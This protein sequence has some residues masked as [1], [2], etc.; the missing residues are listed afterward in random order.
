VLGCKSGIIRPNIPVW[1]QAS[2]VTCHHLLISVLQ[3]FS[4][5]ASCWW[6]QVL[7]SPDSYVG[8][9]SLERVLAFVGSAVSWVFSLWGRQIIIFAID[10]AGPCSYSSDPLQKLKSK[11]RSLSYVF[12][13]VFKTS[14]T[15]SN[16]RL[17]A[18]A[19]SRLFP[20]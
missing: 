7:A 5:I 20:G 16:L 14:N 4:T 19:F 8:L 17:L 3:L 2:R 1:V 12:R 18:R 13:T 11:R 10:L 6:A 15:S 9:A